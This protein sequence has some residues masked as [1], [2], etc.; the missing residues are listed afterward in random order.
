MKLT[1]YKWWNAYE[2]KIRGH[3]LPS[4]KQIEK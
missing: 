4:A 3:I 2:N 1:V